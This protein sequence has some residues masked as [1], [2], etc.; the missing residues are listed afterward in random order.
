SSDDLTLKKA[1]TYVLRLAHGE[2]AFAAI[3][4]GRAP[5]AS[6]LHL[7]EGLRAMHNLV[8]PR[9]HMEVTICG[10]LPPFSHVLGGKLVAGFLGHPSILEA[11]SSGPGLILQALFDSEA[12]AVEIPHWGLLA[13]TTR[14]LYPGHSAQYNRASIP[15]ASAPVRIQK[16]GETSGG[17]TT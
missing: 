12:L 16:I 6:D 2:H 9:I 4:D 3:A 8:V 10:A 15:G 17:T 5:N 7:R 14:G 1:I 13:L 11:A